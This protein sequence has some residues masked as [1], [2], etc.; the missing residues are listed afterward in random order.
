MEISKSALLLANEHQSDQENVT[1]EFRII[2]AMYS[3]TQ[4]LLCQWIAR[5]C[6]IKVDFNQN[7]SLSIS[8]NIKQYHFFAG[9][10]HQYGYLPHEDAD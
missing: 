10:T 2:F 9:I 5:K 4:K 7:D 1:N 6:S 8:L 3:F